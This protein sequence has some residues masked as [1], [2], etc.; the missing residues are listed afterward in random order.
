MRAE[1]TGSGKG[2]P[3]ERKK[4]CERNE[5]LVEE[6][7]RRIECGERRKKRRIVSGRFFRTKRRRH[8]PLLKT[9]CNRK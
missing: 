4:R 6:N 9:S 3:E 2:R 1:V 8:L 5:R 7:E